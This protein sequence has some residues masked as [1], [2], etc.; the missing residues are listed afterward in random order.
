MFVELEALRQELR[1]AQRTAE[2]QAMAGLPARE[3]PADQ[4]PCPSFSLPM[5]T[6]D[7]LEELNKL[8]ARDSAARK[9]LVSIT[10][11]LTEYCM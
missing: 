10:I 11:R 4:L 2:L 1:Q 7:E 5:S 3:A 6:P 9:A 8:L